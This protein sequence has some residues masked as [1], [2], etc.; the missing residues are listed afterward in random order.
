MKIILFNTKKSYIK[1][2]LQSICMSQLFYYKSYFNYL[3]KI[4]NNFTTKILKDYSK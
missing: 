1:I 4:L 2:I 3:T